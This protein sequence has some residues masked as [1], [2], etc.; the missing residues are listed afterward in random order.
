MIMDDDVSTEGNSAYQSNVQTPTGL[1]SSNLNTMTSPRPDVTHSAGS[2]PPSGSFTSRGRNPVRRD[3]APRKE[4]IKDI[5]QPYLSDSENSP[6]FKPLIITIAVRI[7]WFLIS[8]YRRETL[9]I[10]RVPN[11]T[12]ESILYQRI[13]QIPTV[14]STNVKESC[15]IWNNPWKN[16]KESRTNLGRIPKNERESLTIPSKMSENLVR[17]FYNPFKYQRISRNH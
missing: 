7:S 12:K 10:P 8:W 4:S 16:V 5:L 6:R 9:R 17:M 11:D 14:M 2:L 15:C 1:I 3:V 13:S